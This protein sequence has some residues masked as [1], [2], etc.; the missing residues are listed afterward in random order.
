MVARTRV[1]RLLA[2]WRGG[3][4]HDL[5][6]VIAAIMALG[7]LAHDHGERIESLDVNPFYVR[8]AG[9][10]AVALDALVVPR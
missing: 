4:A 9:Q 8:P 2:G 1:G 6:A 5:D 10:G 3:V 7:R